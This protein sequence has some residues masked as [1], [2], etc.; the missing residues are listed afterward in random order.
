MLRSLPAE[1]APPTTLVCCKQTDQQSIMYENL[2]RQ[3]YSSRLSTY[4]SEPVSYEFNSLP[5][6]PNDLVNRSDDSQL[7]DTEAISLKECSERE[8]KYITHTICELQYKYC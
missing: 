5:W 3:L 8:R 1:T 2:N 6:R 4:Y 7:S